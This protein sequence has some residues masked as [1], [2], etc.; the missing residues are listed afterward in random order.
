VFVNVILKNGEVKASI[1]DRG[2]GI[3]RE[4]LW[5]IFER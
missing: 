2:I 4:S 5:K 1:K 3:E